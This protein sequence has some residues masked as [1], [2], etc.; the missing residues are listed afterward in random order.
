[1]ASRNIV[2]S[3]ILLLAALPVIY[4]DILYW[5]VPLSSMETKSGW[6]YVV[7]YCIVG[8][9]M[10]VVYL[11]MKVGGWIARYVDWKSLGW[12]TS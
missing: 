3:L 7:I 1:M 11:V 10:T 6:A 9:L 8:M 4:F 5:N 2:F 12:R